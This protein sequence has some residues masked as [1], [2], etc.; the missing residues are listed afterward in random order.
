MWSSR[1]FWK[2]FLVYAGLNLTLAVG[3]LIVVT[4]WQRTQVNEQ[5]RQRLHDTAVVL[6]SHTRQQIGALLD[7]QTAT[8]RKQEL[9]AK[10]QQLVRNISQRTQTRLTLVAA[11][12]QV[13][14]DSE[15]DPRE[16]NNHSDRP[17]LIAAGRDGIGTSIRR[18]PTLG[19]DMSY[20]AL[21]IRENDQ[22]VA[23]VRTAMELETINRR[24]AAIRWF[25]W[26]FAL[27]VGLIAAALT[28]AVVGRVIQPLTDLTASAQAIAAGDKDQLVRVEGKDETAQLANAFGQMHD[29]LARRV[30]Q[31]RENRDQ[32]ATVLGSMSEGII[33]VDAN[34]KIILANQ[35]SRELL[36]LSA[37]NIEGRSLIEAVRIHPLHQTVEA[38]RT[39]GQSRQT[40]FETGNKPRRV[41][42]VRVTCLPGDPSPG[43]VIV[44]HDVTEL[45]RL[46]NLRYDFFANVSHELKTPLAAIKASAETLRLGA[47][48]DAEHNLRFVTCIEEQAERLYQLILDMLHIA[49][50]EA[51]Q[52]SFDITDVDVA[53]IV[54]DCR[55]H[56]ANKAQLNEIALAVQPPDESLR[57]RADKDGLRIILENLLDNAVKYTPQGGRVTVDWE[58]QD[59]AVVLRVKDTGI[60]IAAADQSRVF[61]RFF[62]VDKARSRDIGGTGLGLSIVKHLCQAFGGSV[63]LQ[64]TSGQGSTF[65]IKLPVSDAVQPAVSAGR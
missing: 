4:A 43:T 53:D 55:A 46:E 50:I 26:L 14:A 19:I 63:N 61:E 51:G 40:E 15:R 28:Y 49:R 54:E 24:V 52:E 10:L 56:A 60:G 41:L 18:S 27:I 35:A 30:R 20:L 32:M 2:L 39:D 37:E 38:A 13:L 16:M 47:I 44:L 36:R 59:G 25:L 7:D 22:T 34:Q 57:V 5:V 9:R 17:E 33:A 64:S 1:L 65:T 45:R 42:S 48:N 3:F 23:L 6:R 31:S 12:G 21:P 62:R 8:A 58:L 29:E 11:S